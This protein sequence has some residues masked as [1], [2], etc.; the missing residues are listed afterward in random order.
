[1]EDT[2]QV[3]DNTQDVTEGEVTDEQVDEKQSEEPD[4]Q[5]EDTEVQE[6]TDETIPEETQDSDPDPLLKG[7]QKGYTQTRQDMAN[8]LERLDKMESNKTA[9][10]KKED[11]Y[12]Y[13]YETDKSIT[14][15]EVNRIIEEREKAKQAEV[16]KYQERIDS[17]INDL[18][19]Q[20][21]IKSKEDEDA[22]VQIALKYKTPDLIVAS[23]IFT[24]INKAKIERKKVVAKGK[25]KAELGGKVGTSQK[26]VAKPT[27]G[28]NY[29]E[30]HGKGFYDLID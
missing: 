26:V 6:E 21:I 30:I 20:G 14:P 22:I 15:D 24:E 7:L 18:K 2:D 11:D 9:P 16:A 4:T 8:I 19:V 27:N 23:Q 17:E 29:N 3:L 12:A 13:D 1:M 25:A 10:V 5:D 28:V